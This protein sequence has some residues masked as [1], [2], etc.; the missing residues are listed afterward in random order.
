M[1]HYSTEFMVIFSE[2]IQLSKTE[3]HLKKILEGNELFKIDQNKNDKIEYKNYLYE[4]RIHKNI[5]DITKYRSYIIKTFIS[6][7]KDKNEESQKQNY[8]EFNS[9]IL[10]TLNEVKHSQLNILRDDISSEY[11]HLAYRAIHDIENKMRKLITI[12][13]TVNIGLEWIV[14]NTPQSVKDSIRKNDIEKDDISYNNFLSET[15]FIQLSNFLFFKYPS[16]QLDDAHR[17]LQS[18]TV[19]IEKLKGLIPKSNW[20]RLFSKVIIDI[21][22]SSIIKRWKNL[23]NLRNKIAHNRFINF[24]EY[25]NIISDKKKMDEVIDK[26]LTNINILEL[27]SIEKE[28]IKTEIKQN[29]KHEF[30]SEKGITLKNLAE[31]LIDKIDELIFFSESKTD[32][33]NLKDYRKELTKM[34]RMFEFFNKN[35]TY[36]S[37]LSRIV[38]RVGQSI[39]DYHH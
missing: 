35:D 4:I 3:L 33:L 34:M 22:E 5:S 28:N 31:E 37:D 2:D 18:D 29:N 16:L 14:S 11:C 26:A 19:N 9:E 25:R 36:L 38:N 12:I 8:S 13:M 23:Y 7:K 21:D 30:S 39:K 6:I 1:N 15:D 32:E 20:E 10:R 27:S 24:N 17:E